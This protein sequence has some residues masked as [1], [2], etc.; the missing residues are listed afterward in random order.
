[1]SVT[2][3]EGINKWEEWDKIKQEKYG[4]RYNIVLTNQA[5]RIGSGLRIVYVKEGRKWAHMV[6]HTGDPNNREG[7]V[8]KK[9][10]I[11]KWNQ[12]KASHERY[13]KRND[14]DE[15]ARKLSRKRYRRI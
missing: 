7:K 8:V 14:P 6:S 11:N 3:S 10:S 5:P 12:I 13:L 2:P 1:L 4:T 15:V 9:L